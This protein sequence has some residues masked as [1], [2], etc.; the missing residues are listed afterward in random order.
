MALGVGKVIADGA[1]YIGPVPPQT[2]SMDGTGLIPEKIAEKIPTGRDRRLR[3]YFWH[4]DSEVRGV[5]VFVHGL[6]D[7]AARW[8]DFASGVCAS[9]WAVLGFDLPGHGRS[10]GKPGRVDSFDGLLADIATAVESAR[11]RYPQLPIV[12]MGH[13]MGGNLALNFALRQTGT[14]AIDADALPLAG[15]V[16]AAPMIQPPQSLPRPIIMAA[17]LTGHLFPWLRFRRP[18]DVSE[19]TGDEAEAAAIRADPEMHSEI[20]MYLATQLVSQGRWALDHARDCKTATLV[21][22]GEDDTLIDKTACDHLAIRMGESATLVKWPETRHALFHER[23]R[24]AVL[25]R[26]TK[27]LNQRAM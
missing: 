2:S 23:S 21:M 13:S 19:L 5:L 20:S 9:G 8:G 25:D 4:P 17:W 27:W 7:H 11:A 3:G 22:Y 18:I 15:L 26:L 1:T 14:D 24:P 12:L 10:P 16:L 6:G